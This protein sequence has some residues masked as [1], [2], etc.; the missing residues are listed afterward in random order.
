MPLDGISD[1]GNREA[2]LGSGRPSRAFHAVHEQLAVGVRRNGDTISGP[3][4]SAARY[5]A[6]LHLEKE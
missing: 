3:M 4:N 6:K 5:V 1:R 2:S